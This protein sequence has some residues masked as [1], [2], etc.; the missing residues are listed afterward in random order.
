MKVMVIGPVPPIRGGIADTNHELC[1]LLAQENEVTVI[2]FKWI[3]PSFFFPQTQVA[4]PKHAYKTHIM[5]EG[6]NP[7]SWMRAADFILRENP[8]SVLFHWWTTYL[9][10]CY[11]FIAWRIGSRIK[12]GALVHNVFPHGVDTG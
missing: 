8:D 7:F 9:F 4:V 2:S 5:L 6:L 3:Y 1:N 12:K 10:P 11:F